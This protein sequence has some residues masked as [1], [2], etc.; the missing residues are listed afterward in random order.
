M[1]WHCYI[2]SHR[3]L[4]V[5]L[6]VDF[7]KESSAEVKLSVSP[8]PP[9]IVSSIKLL[10][11]FFQL[12]QQWLHYTMGDFSRSGFVG[13]PLY[14]LQDMETSLTS[15]Y[16]RPGQ[17]KQELLCGNVRGAENSTLVDIE[18]EPPTQPAPIFTYSLPG[19]TT[20]QVII[21][22]DPLMQIRRLHQT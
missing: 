9:K 12:N 6:P 5:V 14:P 7:L 4:A 13:D 17:N 3:G 11:L 19:R 2:F 8:K 20:T 1:P 22:V 16:S 21:T 18:V 10:T 15:K